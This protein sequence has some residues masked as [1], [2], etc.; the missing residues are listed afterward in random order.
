M[1]KAPETRKMK[2]RLGPKRARSS[3][4]WTSRGGSK[5]KLFNLNFA[6][7]NE[8]KHVDEKAIE[9]VSIVSEVNL[10]EKLDGLILAPPTMVL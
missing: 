5:E 3:V 2:L 9:L 10:V 7:V 8:V 1:D 6:Q 4:M